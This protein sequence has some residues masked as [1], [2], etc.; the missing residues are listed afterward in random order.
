MD[1]MLRMSRSTRA[2]F[3][4]LLLSVGGAG[5]V[6]L[7]AQTPELA[8][9][10]SADD[11]VQQVAEARRLTREMM[12]ESGTPGVS[13]AV[14]VN[15]RLLWSE[16]F[17]WADLELKVPVTALTKFRVGSVS[18]PMTAVA[19]ALLVDEGRLDLDSTIQTYVPWFPEKRWPVTVRQVAGHVGGVR[20]YQGAE[21]FSSERY[22]DVTTGLSIF[23]DDTLN[24]QP[25]TEF[26]YSSYGWNLLSGVVEGAAGEEFLPYMR[27]RVFEPMGLLHTVADH[28]DSI[29]SG[30]TR[31]YVQSRA[32][33]RVRNAPYVDNSY[34]WA[35]GGFL[36]TPEDLLRFGSAHLN[37][38][39][40][41]ESTLD[42][43]FTSQELSD[44]AATKYGIGWFVSPDDSNG[45]VVYHSGGS[46]GGTTMLL[47]NRDT[48]LVVAAVGNMSGVP[49]G[50]LARE[51]MSI[52]GEN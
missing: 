35:G 4:S 31:F 36:S 21:N 30:R 48:G 44:G 26:S 47:V 17:G 8:A 42:E 2:I 1:A 52:F 49:I 33:G 34:K 5:V 40:I 22:S 19:L 10:V 28:N 9:V 20:H 11:H 41:S 13:V 16:G 43:W 38:G 18:K 7:Q 46:V 23:A 45:R 12:A 6:P 37:P 50:A 3:L 14:G 24:F 29:I 39:I 15:G 32:D 25:G 27:D 51:I